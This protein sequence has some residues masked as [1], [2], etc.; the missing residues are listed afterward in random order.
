[1]VLQANLSKLIKLFNN[2]G[3]CCYFSIKKPHIIL[4]IETICTN[5]WRK[6]YHYIIKVGK[7]TQHSKF[8]KYLVLRVKSEWGETSTY[9]LLG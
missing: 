5:M 4:S 9:F 3:I 6:R 7:V 2:I 8:R 1:M